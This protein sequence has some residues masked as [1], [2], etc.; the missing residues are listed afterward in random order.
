MNVIVRPEGR[1]A[2][3]AEATVD[4]LWLTV[5]L[6]TGE[7]FRLLADGTVTWW[8]PRYQ[9]RVDPQ[10]RLGFRGGSWQEA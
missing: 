6:E 7:R 10:M 1:Y 2:F 8:D 5:R 9:H 3:T 4:D